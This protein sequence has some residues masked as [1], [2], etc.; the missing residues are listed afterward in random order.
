MYNYP[1]LYAPGCDFL[2]TVAKNFPAMKEAKPTKHKKVR[3]GL[4]A[5]NSKISSCQWVNCL[6]NEKKYIYTHHC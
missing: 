4:T 1:Y 3:A 5:H 2:D 6:L